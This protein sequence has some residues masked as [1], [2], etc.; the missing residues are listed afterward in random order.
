MMDLKSDARRVLALAQAA[1]SPSASDKARVEQK[2]AV[3]LGAAAAT[4]SALSGDALAQ[5][6]ALGKPA[7]GHAVYVWIA[8]AVLGAAITTA[9]LLR[10]SSEAPTRR[11]ERGS[12]ELETPPLA[13]APESAAPAAA[14]AE[15]PASPAPPPHPA[16]ARAS[17][18]AGM[19]EVVLLQRAQIAWREGAAQRA[20]LLLAEH[21][22][23]YPRSPLSLERDALRILAL[24]QL[25]ARSEA[26]TRM[27]AL[28]AQNP[29]AP[30]RTSIEQSCALK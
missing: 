28:F 8:G 18:A 7:A 24:C 5:A 4:G 15:Q 10:P 19:Q 12:T 25:G 14:P 3:A 27:R 26:R 11:M 6:A 23:T 9:S 21:R 29:A 13:A 16:R 1:R 30:M 22:R 2:L 17:H 20:L